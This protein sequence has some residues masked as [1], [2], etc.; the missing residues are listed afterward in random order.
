MGRMKSIISVAVVTALMVPV[1]A[2]PALAED[3]GW[4]DDDY[5]PYYHY[6]DSWY[7]GFQDVKQEAESGDVAIDYAVSNEGDY[8]QQS[9]PAL[10]FANTG[11][12]NNAPSFAQY[13]SEAD[14]FEP[15]GIEFEF[16]PT[17]E[18]ASDQTVEQ[19]TAAG[20][21]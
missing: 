11:N 14:D 15:G 9:T 13:G 21:W 8:A 3:H 20:R 5:Y 16:A 1:A 4:H 12:L 7:D 18:S 19:S 6:Y 2:V 17:L 10:H